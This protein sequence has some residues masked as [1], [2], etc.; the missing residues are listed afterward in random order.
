MLALPDVHDRPLIDYDEATGGDRHISP[1]MP[2]MIAVPTTAGTG[3]EVGRSAVV[4]LDA[5]KRKT[6]IFS[7]YLQPSVAILDPK[8]TT[9]LPAAA[10]RHDRLRRPVPLHRGVPGPRRPPALR[11][12]RPRRDPAHRGANL[13]RAFQTPDDIEARGAMQKAAM[14]GAVAFQKGLGA[15]QALAHPL[16]NSCGIQQGLGKALC[17][18]AVVD[19]NAPATPE[20]LRAVAEALGVTDLAAGLRQLRGELGLPSGLREAGVNEDL[21]PSLAAEAAEDASIRTNPRPCGREELLGMYR[22][23]L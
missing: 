23:S 3:S 20:R 7:P 17:L 6:V 22:A 19:F 8:L 14:M 4:T 18:P 21:I 15:G 12:H 1:R 2:A 10:H 16:A 5:N 13:R 11:R 9:T